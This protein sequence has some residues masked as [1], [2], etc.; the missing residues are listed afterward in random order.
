M[1]TSKVKDSGVKLVDFLHQLLN[2]K[3]SLRKIKQAIEN[4]YCR[5]NGEIERFYSH[6]LTKGDGVAFDPA[7]FEEVTNPTS[8][9][10]SDRILFEDDHLLIYNKPSGITSDKTGLGKI[11]PD[12]F[13]IHRL[14]KETTGCIMFAK[15]PKV[16]NRMIDLFKEKKI[17][18]AYLAVVDGVPKR[19]HGIE[20]SFIGK[21]SS[22]P[23]TIK[24]GVVA[25]KMGQHAITEWSVEK[26]GKEACLL[27]MNPVSG[28]TH[29]LRVH[30]KHIG[31]PIIGDY[32][33]SRTFQCSYQ[34]MR[35][36]LH[37]YTLHFP[38]PILDS[39][40]KVKAPIATDMKK[41]IR[42]TCR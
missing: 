24:W 9:V 19:K 18:K 27:R 35:T 22:S 21:L 36:L 12:Y 1:I 14:D 20:E 8:K 11:F 30:A 4:N 33:Y 31:H 26:K 39:Y 37:A 2:E 6:K 32:R 38:H 15:Y 40:I 34:A 10:E 7:A 16:K 5:V 29:Q 17:S 28:R 3:Y 25:P 13:L 42:E 23:D 41:A